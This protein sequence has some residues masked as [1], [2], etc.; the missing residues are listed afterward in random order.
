MGILFLLGLTLEIN[1]YQEQN[2]DKNNE[3]N[4][5]LVISF[6]EYFV[7]IGIFSIGKNHCDYKSNKKTY[8]KH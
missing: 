6:V 4:Q 8:G 7:Q 5:N 1:F 2:Q 3:S